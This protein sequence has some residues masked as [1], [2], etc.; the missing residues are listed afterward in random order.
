MTLCFCLL[1]SGWLLNIVF[2]V[3]QHGSKTIPLPRVTAN[4]LLIQSLQKLY[5]MPDCLLSRCL[6]TTAPLSPYQTMAILQQWSSLTQMRDQVGISDKI[7]TAL[8]ML[9]SQNEHSFEQATFS[10]ACL[11]FYTP[12]VSSSSS[13]CARPL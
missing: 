3:H 13:R 9:L 11:G 6:T 1:L 10:S 8:K 5:L 2:Q 7:I 12:L 4:H